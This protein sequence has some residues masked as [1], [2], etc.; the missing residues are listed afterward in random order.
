MRS[1]PGGRT[2]CKGLR[3][4]DDG[5][6]NVPHRATAIIGIGVIGGSVGILALG[7]WAVPWFF[8]GRVLP[9]VFAWQMSLA[10]K[11][12]EEVRQALAAALAAEAPRVRFVQTTET[13]AQDSPRRLEGEIPAS[14]LGAEPDLEQTAEA[15][16]TIGRES[17]WRSLQGR[18]L[19]LQGRGEIPVV[20]RVRPEVAR[21]AL[22]QRF[23]DGFREP[24]EPSWELASDGTFT[25]HPG[26]AGAE[27]ALDETVAAVTERLGL[28][29][30]DPVLLRVVV[31]PVQTSDKDARVAGVAAAQAVARPLTLIVEQQK[32]VVPS[33]VLASWVFGAEST[34]GEPR[35]H[36]AAIEQY[37]RSTVA[38]AVAQGPV[39]AQ[40]QVS[41]NRATVFTPPTPGRE[42]LVAESATG[43][44]RGL[45]AGA[46]S[47]KLMTRAVPPA[48]TVTPLM[49]EYGIRALIARGESD[50]ARSP[51]NRIHNIR[52][53]AEKYHGLLVSPGAEFSFNQNLGPVD[54]KHGFLP[55]LVILHN[56]TT[57]QYGG[58]LCQVSTTMFRSA[59][60]AGFPVTA[61]RNHAYAVSY[62]GIPGF[63]ATIYPPNPDLRFL[64]D[65]P[66]HLLIQMKLQG[67]K[68]AFEFWGTPDGRKVE[69][70][71]P[72]PYDRRK[73]G[74][75]KARLVRTVTRGGQAT[76]DEWQSSYKSPKLF[77]KVLAANA[78]RR[79]DQSTKTPQEV[80]PVGPPEPVP[81]PTPK[82][83]PKPTPTPAPET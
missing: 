21:T 67:T 54:G 60:H 1:V 17:G 38:T 51:K 65:M 27:I 6:M 50:F 25:F 68:L 12:R 13:E 81:S 15:A 11:T 43:I 34:A 39:N 23:P 73:D 30:T 52:V 29:R 24:K 63:D 77:P 53:G 80:V 78:E 16:L 79:W 5:G 46:E 74:A 22:Q 59:V 47:V 9:G 82:P 4:C 8:E 40:F 28:R 37:L 2:L 69:V 55:E 61:R 41:E 3:L 83:A 35:L 62:Y 64:N 57:P 26:E 72:F 33:D 36:R 19:L 20:W 10:G 66:G 71:G 48:V 70:Q 45:V 31:R 7:L 44:L 56:V 32:I 14:V 58:G 42:L 49:E 18:V 76:S 75:V